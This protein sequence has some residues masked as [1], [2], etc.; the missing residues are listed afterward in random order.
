MACET[1]EIFF[2][3]FFRA[4]G[5]SLQTGL[6]VPGLSRDGE[7][8]LGSAVL[9]PRQENQEQERNGSVSENGLGLSSSKV[10]FAFFVTT[11]LKFPP[12][13][14][15]L[16]GLSVAGLGG[17]VLLLLGEADAE[18]TE[19]V[20]VGG[21][22]IDVSLDQGLPLLDHGPQLVSGQVHSVEVAEA[23]LALD[24]LADELELT[25]RSLRVG[26]VLEIGQRD[27]VDAALQTVRSD[28]K[29][30]LKTR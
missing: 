10:R 25:E 16:L 2:F 14:F 23:V 4:L 22:D 3:V 29:I 27:L 20:S 28:P 24:V 13:V 5:S 6:Y 11:V 17:L 12:I 1:N 26:L 7:P 9:V 8:V 18:D 19:E 21:L 15:Y 30:I